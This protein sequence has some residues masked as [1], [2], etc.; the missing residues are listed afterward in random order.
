MNDITEYIKNESGIY[1]SVA[2]MFDNDVKNVSLSESC[3]SIIITNSS[4][5]KAVVLLEDY[6]SKEVTN[7]LSKL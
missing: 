6:L 7:Y 1:Q 3:K 2:N 5:E 4:N